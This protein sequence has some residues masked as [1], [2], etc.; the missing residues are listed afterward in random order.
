MVLTGLNIHYIALSNLYAMIKILSH[1][2]PKGAVLTELVEWL[3]EVYVNDLNRLGFQMRKYA[4]V[5]D[6]DDEEGCHI[7]KLEEVYEAGQKSI[8]HD[9]RIVEYEAMQNIC[10]QDDDGQPHAT[11]RLHNG[12]L[13]LFIPY[14][15]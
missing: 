12:T 13:W 9:D 14:V 10:T 6:K 7:L 3:K 5:W 2:V 8:T 11:Y 4:H 1:Q 15:S